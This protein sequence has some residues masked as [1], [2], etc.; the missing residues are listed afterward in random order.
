MSYIDRFFIALPIAEALMT[1]D[2]SKLNS[3]EKSCLEIFLK[4]RYENESFVMADPRIYHRCDLTD[5][6][7]HC[8][9]IEL[10]SNDE[11][12]EVD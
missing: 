2:T 11:L 7:G 3:S 9:L 5:K 12:A 8:A 1:G 4:D 6:W 10:W